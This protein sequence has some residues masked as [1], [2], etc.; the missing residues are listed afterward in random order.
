MNELLLVIALT[1]S[2]GDTVDV[3]PGMKAVIVPED[4][5]HCLVVEGVK[6]VELETLVEP[7]G[8]CEGLTVSPNFCEED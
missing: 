8:N 1:L 7:E 2:N 5:P 6:F 3:P 4:I